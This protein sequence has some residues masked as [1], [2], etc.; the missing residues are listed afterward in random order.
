[1]DDRKESFGASLVVVVEEEEDKEEAED[2]DEKTVDEAT[3]RMSDRT[4]ALERMRLVLVMVSTV[5]CVE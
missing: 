4:Q 2:A 3:R 5:G 1:M